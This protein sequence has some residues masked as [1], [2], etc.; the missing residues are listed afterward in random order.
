MLAKYN[1]F[2]INLYSLKKPTK[3]TATLLTYLTSK[4][5]NPP[6]KKESCRENNYS[7]DLNAIILGKRVQ[8]TQHLSSAHRPSQ[9]VNRLSRLRRH[10]H[11][12]PT[13]HQNLHERQVPIHRCHNQRTLLLPITPVHIRPVSDQQLCQLNRGVHARSS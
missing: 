3:C 4:Q 11:I 7:K 5:I 12:R 1:N 9:L 6:I 8:K 10:M 13:L 2:I